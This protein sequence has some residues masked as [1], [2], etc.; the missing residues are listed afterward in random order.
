M[1]TVL[2][3]TVVDAFPAAAPLLPPAGEVVAAGDVLLPAISVVQPAIATVLTKTARSAQRR[4]LFIAP[5]P[6]PPFARI[7]AR[8]DSLDL[9]RRAGF[10]VTYGDRN[11]YRYPRF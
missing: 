6:F 8:R 2:L 3:F 11:I 7:L 1:V 5:L 9:Q 10:A 4:I